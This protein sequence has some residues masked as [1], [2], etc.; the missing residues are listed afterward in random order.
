MKLEIFNKYQKKIIY[1]FLVYSWIEL[2]SFITLL[3][4]AKKFPNTVYSPPKIINPDLK[5]N[6]SDSLGWGSKTVQR[7]SNHKYS[8]IN[9]CRIH[10]FGDSYMQ[11]DTYKK[12]TTK[13]GNKKTPENFLSKLTNCMVFNHGQ[14]GYG[15]DQSYL[16][17]L[18]KV[19][20][21]T[22][23]KG[24]FV[25]MSHLTEN[26]LRNANKNRS[27][28]YQNGQTPL[29]KP[30]FEIQDGK[31]DLINIPDSIDKK[32]LNSL[33]TSRY[34]LKL[35][36][37]EHP[38]FIPG[39]R[40]GSPAL[41]AYPY[42]FNIVRAI[43]SYHSLPRIFR[44]TRYH[45]FYKEKS[46]SYQVTIQIIKKF[47]EKCAESGCFSLSVDLPLADDFGKYFTHKGNKF[48]LSNDL[49]RM[50]INHVSIGQLQAETFPQLRKNKC[51]LHD[52]KFDGGDPCNG[53]YNQEG[54]SSFLSHLARLIKKGSN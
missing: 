39:K 51:Y 37:A 45:S 12:I 21:L 14:N 6:L 23:K 13:N 44:R 27:L 15:S 53:H 24:D 17:F 29:L 5:K 9:R 52:G 43:A 48:I 10:L 34:P 49:K 4:I 46:E 11:A 28:L 38:K 35:S 30:K 50:G 8:E 2:I 18:K 31:L 20:D 1:I 42:T 32:T 7:S 16:K 3:G 41:I 33:L 36:I 40:W 26:I 47:H 54:Y 19:E 25:V 22:I